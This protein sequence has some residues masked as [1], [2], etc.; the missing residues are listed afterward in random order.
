MHEIMESGITSKEVEL[1]DFYLYLPYIVVE[2][3]EKER[4]PLPHLEAIYIMLP[5]EQVIHIA[6]AMLSDSNLMLSWY[7]IPL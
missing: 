3:L 6:V 5:T 7:F 2:S 1:M 4:E